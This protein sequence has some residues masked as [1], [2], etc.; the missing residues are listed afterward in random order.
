MRKEELDNLEKYYL[1]TIYIANKLN[2][3]PKT[4]FVVNGSFKTIY[5]VPIAIKGTENINT[6]TFVGPKIGVEY[7]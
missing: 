7:I 1:L 2:N 3:P 5:A 6:L 4:I